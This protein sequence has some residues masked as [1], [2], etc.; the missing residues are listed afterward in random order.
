MAEAAPTAAAASEADSAGS[1]EEWVAVSV[2][3]EQVE[4]GRMVQKQVRCSL[5]IDRQ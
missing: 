5:F 3:V 2:E 4:A 1:A